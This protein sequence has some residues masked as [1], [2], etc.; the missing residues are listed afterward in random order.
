[1][2]T[3]TLLAELDLY[4]LILLTELKELRPTDYEYYQ[5]L[6]P[7]LIPSIN[8]EFTKEN[9]IKIYPKRQEIVLEIFRRAME[10]KEFLFFILWVSGVKRVDKVH[11]CELFFNLSL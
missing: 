1:M 10:N 2:N 11:F 6:F 7:K 8:S 9:S 5:S 3:K 4:I